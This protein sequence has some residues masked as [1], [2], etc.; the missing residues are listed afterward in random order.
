MFALGSGVA[1]VYAADFAPRHL[2]SPEG[3]HLPSGVVAVARKEMESL[4]FLTLNR[5]V[6]V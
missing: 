3:R 2:K 6:T 5:Q 1:G 4:F